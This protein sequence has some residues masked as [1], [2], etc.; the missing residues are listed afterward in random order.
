RFSGEG[1]ER[2]Q[3]IADTSFFFTNFPEHFLERDLWK[4][5]Q[6]WGRFLDVFVSRKFNA[7]NR[8]F[9]FVRFQ[10]VNDVFSLERELDAIWIGTC[11]LQVNLPK[12][13]RKD[14]PRKQ[15]NEGSRLGWNS[16]LNTTHP[17]EGGNVK[18]KQTEQFS[19]AQVV[20]DGVVNNGTGENASMEVEQDSW[21]EGS[22]VG[23]FKEIPCFQSIKESFVMGGFSLVK[24]RYLG[25]RFVLLSCEEEGSLRKIIANNKSWFDEV[26]SSVTPWDGSFVLKERCEW[27]RCRGIPLQLWCNQSFSKVGAVVGEVVEIDE[28]TEKRETLEFA[29]VRAKTSVNTAINME[30]DFIINGCQCKVTFEEE[31]SFPEMC[32]G[33]WDGGGS[34]VDTEASSDEG[35]LGASLC[36]SVGSEFGAAGEGGV[37]AVGGGRLGNEETVQGKLNPNF[38]GKERQLHGV[39]AQAHLRESLNVRGS[40]SSYKKVESLIGHGSSSSSMKEKVESTFNAAVN[41]SNEIK[42]A[43][44]KEGRAFGEGADKGSKSHSIGSV[45]ERVGASF[46]VKDAQGVM[47]ADRGPYSI[48]KKCSP[49]IGCLERGAVSGK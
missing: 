9:G 15:R 30:K 31:V 8:K 49:F 33:K 12:Y 36:D 1:G 42:A 40:L 24:L 3:S 29:R 48:S 46:Y 13:Q 44:E 10:G 2:Y 14:G 45:S 17:R 6:R 38:L 37:G 43:N 47:H 20:S 32:I 5:F 26:F 18:G 35:S 4:V 34:E 28:A 25:G 22:Y 41:I 7:R 11:K 39:V 27:I 23:S 19:F 16:K 21:L